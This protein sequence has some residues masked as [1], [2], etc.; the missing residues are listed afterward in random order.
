MAAQDRKEDFSIYWEWWPKPVFTPGGL[1]WLTEI[2]ELAGGRN[3]FASEPQANVQ[4]DWEEVAK[5]NPDH[6]CM[7]WVGV[8]EDKVNPEILKKRRGW[9]KVK[10]VQSNQVHVLGDS[11]YCRPSPRLLDGLEKLIFTLSGQSPLQQDGD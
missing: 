1:N 10:A 11:L 3:I 9:E 7:V 6:I 8:E 5:R 4:T 2:S